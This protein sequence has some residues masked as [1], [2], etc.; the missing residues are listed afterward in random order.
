MEEV[1]IGEAFR[2]KCCHTCCAHVLQPKLAYS[3]Q[4][5]VS[6]VTKIC[7][8]ITQGHY[9]NM[10]ERQFAAKK[11]QIYQN[12]AVS[13]NGIKRTP[14]LYQVCGFKS[15]PLHARLTKI[16]FFLRKETVQN[17]RGNCLGDF[18]PDIE[19]NRINL[20]EF[21]RTFINIRHEKNIVE[22][23]IPYG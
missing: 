11:C 9:I 22:N 1:S 14:N 4:L 17:T 20:L 18:N 6:D 16:V 5:A 12:W 15:P 2:I 21:A 23:R 7:Q 10:I 8:L 19:N 3:T 13:W